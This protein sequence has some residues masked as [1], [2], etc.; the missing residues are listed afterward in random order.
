ADSFNINAAESL[1]KSLEKSRP[2]FIRQ[3]ITFPNS[4]VTPLFGKSTAWF[5]SFPSQSKPPFVFQSFVGGLVDFAISTTT[6]LVF[7]SVLIASNFLLI[8]S[9]GETHNKLSRLY[10]TGLFFTC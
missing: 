3:P 2:S 1:A 4:Y 7:N 5:G 10:P 6:L 9:P 8:S